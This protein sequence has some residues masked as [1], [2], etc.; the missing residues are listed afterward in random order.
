MLA[1]AACTPTTAPPGTGWS[2]APDLSAYSAMVLFADIAREQ[3][4]LCGG[5]SPGVVARRWDQDFGA[6]EAAIAA[7]LAARHG[8]GAVAR[9]EAEAV[10]AQRVPC[11]SVPNLD[12]R[13][14]YGRMLRLLEA[15]LGRA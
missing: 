9:A 15:R 7:A 3:S 10:A 8:A 4:V 6:R 12:W 2:R 1:L 14:R 11:P 5:F 13:Y